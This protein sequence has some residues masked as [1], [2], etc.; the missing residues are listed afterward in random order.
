M[1]RVIVRKFAFQTIVKPDV[2]LRVQDV[3]VLN[4]SMEVGSTAQSVT[5]EAGGPLIQASPQRG[6]QLPFARGAYFAVDVSE[7]DFACADAAGSR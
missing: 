1:Y 5:V 2:E 3:V 4:F 7:S 6:G